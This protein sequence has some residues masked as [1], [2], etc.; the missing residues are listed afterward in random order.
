MTFTLQKNS[1]TPI[2]HAYKPSHFISMIFRSSKTLIKSPPRN[3]KV[4]ITI[5][6]T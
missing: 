3:L 4:E 1:M 6:K 2:T 5:A